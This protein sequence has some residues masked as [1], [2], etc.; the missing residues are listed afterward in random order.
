MVGG[1]L[2]PEGVVRFAA[3]EDDGADS[4]GGGASRDR[5]HVVLLGDVVDDEVALGLTGGLARPLGYRFVESRG[6]RGVV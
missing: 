1:S 2:A 6:V 5:A 4:E 3:D